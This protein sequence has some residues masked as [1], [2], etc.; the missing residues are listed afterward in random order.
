M[1]TDKLIHQ[2][3]VELQPIGPPVAIKTD[4]LI[5]QLAMDLRPVK[6]IGRP[7]ARL[8]LWLLFATVFMSLAVY[9]VGPRPNLLAAFIEPTF[10]LRIVTTLCVAV[11]AGLAAFTLAIPGRNHEQSLVILGFAIVTLAIL[12][13]YLFYSAESLAPG[14]GV[15]CARNTMIFGVA[16]S[17][18]L[19]FMLKGGA[20]IRSGTV[21]AL[22]ALG[23]AAFGSVGTQMICRN[24]S[25]MHI[26]VWHLLPIALLSGVGILL[27]RLIFNWN[28]RK[29]YR[30]AHATNS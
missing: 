9:I 10:A 2:L 22:A 3:A 14:A 27:G 4:K 23:A 6:P 19:Y 12:L 5:H 8:T 21:G 1:K 25:P 24:E 11:V 29:S 30:T 17:S 28:D 26:F 16:V 15:R 7:I 18:I 20:P 13:G